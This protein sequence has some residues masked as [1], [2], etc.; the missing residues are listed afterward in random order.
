MDTFHSTDVMGDERGHAFI[1]GI[2]CSRM[3]EDTPTLS[4]APSLSSEIDEGEQ[5]QERDK[6]DGIIEEGLED[7]LMDEDG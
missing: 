1:V 7:M 3:Y 5:V 6:N 4:T 2:E